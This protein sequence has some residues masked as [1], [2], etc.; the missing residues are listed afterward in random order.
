MTNSKIVVIIPA[1]EESTRLEKKLLLNKTGKPLIVHTV[2]RALETGF[3]VYVATDSN[4]ISEC[5]YANMDADGKIGTVRTRKNHENGSSRVLEAA[6]ILDLSPNDIIINLQGDEPEL[7]VS[8]IRR[9]VGKLK[10]DKTDRLIAT[11]AFITDDYNEALLS[12]NVKVVTNRNRFAMYFSRLAI[13][14]H[15]NWLIHSGVYAY[16]YNTLWQIINQSFDSRL[17]ASERLEQLKWLE[18]GIPIYVSL[19]STGHVGID[20]L[21]DYNEFCRRYSETQSAE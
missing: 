2:E 1:R 10:I 21:E 17:Q 4:D 5:I 3:P 18:L 13:P 11:S 20:T 16:T 15:G 9:T 14:T 19:N 6:S 7:P 12:G 8:T